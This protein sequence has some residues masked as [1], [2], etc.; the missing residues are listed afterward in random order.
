MPTWTDMRA[1]IRHLEDRKERVARSAQIAQEGAVADIKQQ[2]LDL[3]SGA[4]APPGA[5]A[6]NGVSFRTGSV[7]SRGLTLTLD[8]LPINRITGELIR[9][10]RVF[11]RQAGNSTYF[12]LQFTSPHAVVLTPGGTRFMKDR[13]FF[14][15]LNTYARG[16]LRSRISDA[17]RSAE[18]G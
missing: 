15:A 5:Y 13:G 10:L 16:V 12:Q 7:S 6:R 8:P 17:I 4:G 9:S 14:V 18:R 2:A 11:R 3:L 1:Y